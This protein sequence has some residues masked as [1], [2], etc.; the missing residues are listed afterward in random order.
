MEDYVCNQVVTHWC[1]LIHFNALS[2]SKKEK[3]Y[4]HNTYNEP[5]YYK[6]A[7]QNLLWIEAMTAELEALRKN[8]TWFVVAL[9]KGKK[10]IGCKIGI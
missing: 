5:S 7:S 2:S 1:K 3:V 9:P 8:N 10:A 4:K 6:E